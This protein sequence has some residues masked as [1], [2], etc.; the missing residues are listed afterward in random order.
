[1][2]TAEQR[3][4][5]VGVVL[6][7]GRSRRMGGQPKAL[8]PLADKSM[9]AHV[10]GTLAPQVGRCIVNAN[11]EVA[12]L[13]ALG[14]PI[15]GDLNDG[16]D[17]PLA[18]IL[19]AM[20]WSGENAPGARWIVTVPCD[21]PFIPADY[22]EQL[23]A[24]AAPRGAPIATASSPSGEHH[25]CGLFSLT[26]V[27]DLAA[28]LARDERRLRLWIAKHR[29]ASAHFDAAEGIDPFF[30]INTPEDLAMAETMLQG[31]RP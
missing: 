19:A 30:N 5:I 11:D 26:L 12:G 8:M 1:M 15:V 22:V 28:W 2:L 27:D 13:R 7:G 16:R 24:A 17:G 10:I 3:D 29:P 23:V 31:G 4:G 18:G 20:V 25:A 9:A 21:T 6:A 14:L